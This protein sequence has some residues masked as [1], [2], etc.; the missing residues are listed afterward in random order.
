[1]PKFPDAPTWMDYTAAPMDDGRIKFDQPENSGAVNS[2]SDGLM[3][4]QY[5]DNELVDVNEVLATEVYFEAP[6]GPLFAQRCGQNIPLHT[7][8]PQ[9]FLRQNRACWKR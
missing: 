7:R 5:A 8:Q 1:M 2:A 4:T 6:S 3:W 9:P